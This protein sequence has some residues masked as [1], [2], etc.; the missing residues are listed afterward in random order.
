MVSGIALNRGGGFVFAGSEGMHIWQ[1][2]G[3]YQTILREHDGQSLSFND[4]V[5][6][7]KGRV[8]AGTLYWNAKRMVRHGKLYLVSPDGKVRVVDEGFSIANGIGFSPDERTMYMSDSGARRIWAYDVNADHGTLHNKRVYVDV[9]HTEGIP[10]G[11]TVD[12]EGFVWS[13]QWYGGQVTRYDPDGHVARRI[14]LPVLQVSSV[15]FGGLDLSELFIT[16]A[17]DAW[18]SDLMPAGYDPKSLNQ[19]GGLYRVAL[20]VPGR[21]E[22]EANLRVPK[23]PQ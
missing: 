19:G 12:S 9:P 1:S 14:A 11:L 13:A 16:S 8:Y 23:V 3:Q 15:A 20:E 10:D 7:S 18:F 6:D 4:I 5:A 17:A 21:R 22:H 2:Q